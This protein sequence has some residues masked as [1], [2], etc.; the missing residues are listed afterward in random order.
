MTTIS[1]LITDFVAKSI[2]IGTL[3]ALDRIYTENKLLHIFGL[4]E[5]QSVEARDPLPASRLTIL[6][7]LI[8]HAVEA[9]IIADR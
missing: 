7:Q 4:N 3:D 2:E 1:Q 8:Q 6:D 9:E 5:L